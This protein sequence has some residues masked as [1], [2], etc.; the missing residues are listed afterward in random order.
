MSKTSRKKDYIKDST[1]KEI[2][3]KLTKTNINQPILKLLQERIED[4]DLRDYKIYIN[5]V[6]VSDLNELNEKLKS[7]YTLKEFLIHMRNLEIERKNKTRTSKFFQS[8]KLGITII[9]E[10]IRVYIHRKRKPKNYEGIGF[11]I[12]AMADTE[13]KYIVLPF[14]FSDGVEF[15]K[16]ILKQHVFDKLHDTIYQ[17]CLKEGNIHIKLRDIANIKTLPVTL[18]KIR[19][20]L[21][22]PLVPLF[23]QFVNHPSVTDD[24]AKKLAKWI[25]SIFP[26]ESS[27][28]D[29]RIDETTSK[30]QLIPILENLC[31]ILDETQSK[32][33]GNMEINALT[34]DFESLKNHKH[35][36]LTTGTKRTT[37]STNVS[38]NPVYLIDN[39]STLDP[40]RTENARRV[41]SPFIAID[42]GIDIESGEFFIDAKK[43]GSDLYLK[44]QSYIFR[45]FWNPDPDVK[46]EFY[47]EIIITLQNV[48][49]KRSGKVNISVELRIG[50]YNPIEPYENYDLF[51]TPN[52]NPATH[53]IDNIVELISAYNMKGKGRLTET[54]YNT[55]KYFLKALGDFLLNMLYFIMLKGEYIQFQDTAMETTNLIDSESVTSKKLSVDTSA[56]SYTSVKSDKSVKMSDET[57]KI[58]CI[59]IAATDRLASAMAI[60]L[61][62][63]TRHERKI[64]T[65][66]KIITTSKGC[67]STVVTVVLDATSPLY[68]QGVLSE[69]LSLSSS[70]SSTPSTYFIQGLNSVSQILPDG[71]TID[72]RTNIKDNN[73]LFRSLLHS[74]DYS[75]DISTFKEYMKTLIEV[76]L[77]ANV[78]NDYFQQKFEED[79][80][81]YEEN[82]FIENL[83]K[84][85]KDLEKPVYTGG[86]LDIKIF[87]VVYHRRV[88]IHDYSEIDD[89][90]SI[91]IPIS[92]NSTSGDIHLYYDGTH[93]ALLNRSPFTQIGGV[94][95]S[96]I[97]EKQFDQSIELDLITD[98][99][100]VF[101]FN[102]LDTNDLTDFINYKKQF[103]RFLSF[104][105]K[106]DISKKIRGNLFITFIYKG[107]EYSFLTSTLQEAID[108]NPT[109]IQ[110]ARKSRVSIKFRPKSKSKTRIPKI[111]NFT[112]STRVSKE[113]DEKIKKTV[114]RSRNTRLKLIESMRQNEP[115]MPR[116]Y[117]Y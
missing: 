19:K 43:N 57:P 99:K 100:F 40:H 60:E 71:F 88:I 85:Y 72:R 91:Y 46:D 42:G 21:R 24:D 94:Q 12:D 115:K 73:S 107:N 45:M 27:V 8:I 51:S 16:Y 2:E 11:N 33:C 37:V 9:F 92:K 95:S 4:G 93:Y 26:N 78:E 106:S 52:T 109:N 32:S 79:L 23:T 97:P 7:T 65:T 41:F 76:Y 53:N 36:D 96:L 74:I 14:E 116:D 56:Q 25:F 112:K 34:S 110:H 48:G 83:I 1:I 63:N 35:A 84:Y 61:T 77:D 50:D 66:C 114:R 68:S 17:R 20:I 3:I 113:I 101:S 81:F 80:S 82:L 18:S 5:N 90:L 15:M 104:L 69:S 59:A 117:S 6:D 22:S 55:T 105:N 89:S 67:I 64:N 31:E 47:Q 10:L 38:E 87:A 49:S 103:N 44:C 70:S 98:N 111:N 30:L 86:P 39:A 102:P 108:L 75:N 54:S 62:L 58:D 28:S 29:L 13:D